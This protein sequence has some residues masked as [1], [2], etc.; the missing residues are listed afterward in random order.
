[1]SMA[2]AAKQYQEKKGLYYIDDSFEKIVVAK[3]G[4]DPMY[5]EE[6]IKI[7]DLLISCWMKIVLIR[8]QTSIFVC[9]KNTVRR[10]AYGVRHSVL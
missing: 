8:E 4:L 5:D 7:I 6:G 1:M 3:T 10:K 9:R 2:D